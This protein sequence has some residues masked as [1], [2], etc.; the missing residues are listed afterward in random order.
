MVIR[1]EMVIMVVMV[2][3][4]AMD[5]M[6][7]MVVIFMV[8]MIVRVVMVVMVIMVIIVIRTDSLSL[9]STTFICLCSLHVLFSSSHANYFNIR[10][11]LITF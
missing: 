1:V 3:M 4:V 10:S 7:I 9:S 2:I 8:I 11:K 5:V 6:V